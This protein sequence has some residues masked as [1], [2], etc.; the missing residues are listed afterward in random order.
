MEWTVEKFDKTIKKA[1]LTESEL[2]RLT[3]FKDL[4]EQGNHPKEAAKNW[5]Y[6]YK[7]LNGGNFK[8]QFQIKLSGGK[9]AT[10]LVHDNVDPGVVEFKQIGG[11]T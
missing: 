1:N 10:F 8:N 11:H 4:V 6:E 3:D 5:D 9:R 7:K 2:R